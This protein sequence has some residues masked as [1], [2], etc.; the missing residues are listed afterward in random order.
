MTF[1]V[2]TV[3]FGGFEHV[4]HLKHIRKCLIVHSTR[5]T[6][7]HLI[8]N[9]RVLDSYKND[10]QN[11]DQILLNVSMFSYFLRQWRFQG[12]REGRVSPGPN[13]LNFI[14]FLG[15][16]GKIVCCRPPS[17][18]RVGAP[19][20]EKSWIRQCEKCKFIILQFHENIKQKEQQ[21]KPTVEQNTSLK[22]M[23]SVDKGSL[24]SSLYFARE[25]LTIFS[26]PLT[27]L[28]TGFI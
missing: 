26:S 14:Q 27:S 7:K 2:Y 15:K 5:G 22:Y 25:P 10:H 16:F 8:L 23:K 9:S 19:T 1:F 13:S 28:V 6:N 20:S 18:R 12:G 17:P 11:D 21:K 24:Y 3:K 4:L